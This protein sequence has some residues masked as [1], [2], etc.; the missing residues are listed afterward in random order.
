MYKTRQNKI[1]KTDKMAI[2]LLN[3]GEVSDYT[4]KI[5]D[6]FMM[7]SFDLNESMSLNEAQILFEEIIREL[8]TYGFEL[9]GYKIHQSFKS[10]GF[11]LDL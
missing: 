8:K 6:D 3:E 2:Q 7:L 5:F 10:I 1:L 4:L 11:D 9:Q